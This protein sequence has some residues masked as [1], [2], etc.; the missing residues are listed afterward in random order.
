[1]HKDGRPPR[2]RLTFGNTVAVVALFVAL[3]GTAFANPI[4]QSATS[5]AK[6]LSKAL[7][8]RTVRTRRRARRWSRPRRRRARRPR[9]WRRPA[10]RARPAHPARPAR[11]ARLERPVPPVRQGPTGAGPAR[12]RGLGPGVRD[13]RVLPG[14]QHV[15]GP[16]CHRMVHAR[17]GGAGRQQ[18]GELQQSRAR[19]LLLPA[20]AVP[21]AQ[22]G[23]EHRPGHGRA[24]NKVYFVQTQVG[25]SE[26]PIPAPCSPKGVA[27]LNAVVYIRDANGALVEPDHSTKVLAL[28]N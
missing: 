20:A 1:M 26:D 15:R 13:D 10:R 4:A 2:S 24:S 18:H 19:C 12:P 7:N 11:P 17:R 21:R 25:T 8:L 28:F 22:P 16:A 3:G 9:R 14:D 5:V 6:K 23:G 27:D